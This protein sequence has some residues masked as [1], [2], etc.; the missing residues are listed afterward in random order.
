MNNITIKMILIIFSFLVSLGLLTLVIMENRDMNQLQELGLLE[1][2][3]KDLNIEMLIL[4]KHEKDFLVRKEIKYLEKFNNTVQNMNKTSEKLKKEL[5]HF[6]LETKEAKKF[7]QVIQKYSKLFREIVQIQQAIG[8]NPKDGLYGSLRDTVHQV[9]EYAKKSNDKNLLSIVYDLR[10]QEKDFMLRN[11]KKYFN[12]FNYKINKLKT[13]IAYKNMSNLLSSY[14]N[15]FNKLVEFEEK[16]GLN[17]ELGLMGKM[18]KIIHTSEKSLSKITKIIEKKTHDKTLEIKTFSIVFSVLIALVIV[19]L[20]LYVSK[21]ISSAVKTSADI[22][23][24][25]GEGRLEEKIVLNGSSEIVELGESLEKM[26]NKMYEQKKQLEEESD[27]L[28][29]AIIDA[30]YDSVITISK[31]GLILSYNKVTNNMFLYG[32]KELINKN[33]NTI[34]SSSNFQ[35]IMEFM[36]IQAETKSLEGEEIEGINKRDGH[37]PVF[38]SV[39]H[40]KRKNE[41]V[42][43]TY[44]KD[45][46]EQKKYEEELRINNQNLINQNWLKTK[47]SLIMEL[48]QGSVNLRQ[49]CDNI[50]SM[51]CRTI[52]A[53]Y[54]VIYIKEEE[55][56]LV[57]SYAFKK[58]NNISETIAIGE[59]LV[60]QCAKEKKIILLKDVPSDYIQISSSL[61][62]KEPLSITLL[63]I[64]FDDNLVGV[65]EIAT[66][67]EYNSMQQK[68]LEEVVSSL[69]IVI[70]NM[71]N[72]ARTQ[73][74]LE[75][76]LTQQEEIRASNEN[77]TKQL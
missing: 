48:T 73:I 42:F 71:K 69:G 52:E 28:N 65:I 66:F 47:T 7:D 2:D 46:T 45:I 76:T 10:K 5:I 50:I 72:T 75:E 43:I 63:P 41:E 1:K 53:G 68:L 23:A 37:F 11:D 17:S 61:G 29:E 62:E 9:Q 35:N 21:N 19:L 55:L 15:D 77:F 57:G 36:N 32:K 34:I 27:S 38:I 8:L 18:R 74:L 70:K 4:R 64:L 44:I 56:M 31:S 59:G 3:I 14:K 13:N 67:K 20:L 40:T 6:K 33:I 51:L 30:S 58:S 16:K 25:I 39:S 60:G 54:G 22:A 12:E 24:K 49:M 26:K